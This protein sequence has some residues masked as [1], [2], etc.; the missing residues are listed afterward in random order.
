MVHGTYSTAFEDCWSQMQSNGLAQCHLEG[1]GE[2][3]AE[4]LSEQWDLTGCARC[5]MPVAQKVV[6][7]TD[8]TCPCTDLPTWPNTE[9]PQPRGEQNWRSQL[10]NINQRVSQSGDRYDPSAG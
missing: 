6:G 8:V 4:L 9:L 7:V 3:L 10:Q 2:S 1:T 5:G